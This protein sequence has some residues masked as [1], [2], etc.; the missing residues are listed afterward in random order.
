[1]AA[2][3]SSKDRKKNIRN[4][5]Q[6][7]NKSTGIVKGQPSESS[8]T[9]PDKSDSHTGGRPSNGPTFRMSLAVPEEYK[10]GLENAA[11]LHKSN[12]TAYIVSLIKKDL[13]ENGEKYA[14]LAGFLKNSREA[15]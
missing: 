9:A 3:A 14:E 2:T 5:G 11:L 7:I 4:F 1:M 13:K 15:K 10:E 8:A 12:K 6:E